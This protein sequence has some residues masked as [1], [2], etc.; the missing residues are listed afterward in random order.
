MHQRRK[1][2]RSTTKN[3]HTK[4]VLLGDRPPNG[5][6]DADL[7]F[8]AGYPRSANV[9]DN[10]EW[11]SSTS[12]MRNCRIWQQA[13]IRTTIETFAIKRSAARC[14]ASPMNSS[15][16]GSGGDAHRAVVRRPERSVTAAEGE[17]AAM[18]VNARL[19]VHC[20]HRTEGSEHAHLALHGILE[21]PGSNERPHVLQTRGPVR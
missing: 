14:A 15:G 11:R 3:V 12:A 18:S 17:G 7:K 21:I 13:P 19:V 5:W 6:D 1:N 10:P 16:A 4:K 9:I 8:P 20:R 2:V